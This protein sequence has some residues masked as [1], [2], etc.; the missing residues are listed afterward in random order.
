M[1]L[2]CKRRSVCVEKIIGVISMLVIGSSVLLAQ[3]NPSTTS[4]SPSTQEVFPGPQVEAQPDKAPASASGQENPPAT[5]NLSQTDVTKSSGEGSRLGPGDL[6]EMSVY[7]VPELATKTRVSDNGDVYLPLI[8]TVHVSGMTP[9]EAQHAIENRLSEGGFL[10]GPHVTLFIDE[11]ASQSVSVLGEVN[12]PGIYPMIGQR[13]LFD[14]VSAAGGFTDKAGRMVTVTHREE[15]DKPVSVKLSRNLGG[16]SDGNVVV[17]AGDTIMVNKADI[18]YVVGDVGR[19]SGLLLDNGSVTVLQAIALAG[20]PNRSAKL[21]AARI[22]RKTPDGMT[23]TPIPLK[24]MLAAKSPDVPMLADD[25]LFVPVND[26]KLAAGR[27]GQAAIQ[28]A[29]AAAVIAV[30]P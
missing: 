16:Q 3:A 20:G 5:T 21:N 19:P 27:I 11:F 25:I 26:A 7:G 18:V 8:D 29:S 10:K 2:H 17:Q 6:L 12:K 9:E 30:A 1:Q 13:R 4:K 28:A 15:P 24:K 14:L 23:E 22:I